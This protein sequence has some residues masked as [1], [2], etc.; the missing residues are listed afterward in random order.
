MTTLAVSDKCIPV[1]YRIE[2][3]SGLLGGRIVWC[4]VRSLVSQQL[5]ALAHAWCTGKQKS[6]AA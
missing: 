4:E 1:V 2:V 5:G 3:W 6:P